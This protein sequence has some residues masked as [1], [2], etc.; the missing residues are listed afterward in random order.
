ML[1]VCRPMVSLLLSL[2]LLITPVSSALAALWADVAQ[3]GAATQ[4]AGTDMADHEDMA[5]T[6]SSCMDC[7]PDCCAEEPC[8]GAGCGSCATSLLPW[9]LSLSVAAVQPMQ[10]VVLPRY[11]TLLATSPFRPPRG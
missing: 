6:M 2:V 10:T 11:S 7:A 4:M 5:V 8:A 1:S 3:T 9:P